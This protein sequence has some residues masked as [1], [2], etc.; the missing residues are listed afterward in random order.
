MKKFLVLTLVLG[1]ASLASAGWSL[2]YDGAK[3]SV[4]T[5]EDLLG[6]INNGLGIIDTTATTSNLT[7]ATLTL[8]TVNAPSGDEVIANYTGVQGVAYYT[9][10]NGGFN[11]LT[12]GDPDPEVAAPAGFW[13]SMALSGYQ[14][15]TEA[16][17]DIQVDVIDGNA[18]SE[19]VTMY[20]SEVP[21]PATMALLGL[22]GMFLARR[23]K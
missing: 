16:S 2:A 17:H 18:G 4:S 13:F 9:G 8:R 10:Y 5:D 7:S 12:W 23:K 21:E 15:G 3:I 20:L 19:G 6:G 1:I 11:T 22:G 14:A